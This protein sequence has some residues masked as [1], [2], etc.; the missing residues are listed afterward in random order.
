[1]RLDNRE[2]LAVELETSADCQNILPQA[3]V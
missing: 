1:V 2:H 3:M